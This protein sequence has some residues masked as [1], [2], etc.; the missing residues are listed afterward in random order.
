MNHIIEILGN[1]KLKSDII[2]QIHNM[3]HVESFD[4]K[5]DELISKIENF[6]E[7]TSSIE[8]LPPI[9]ENIILSVGRPVIEV[10]HNTFVPPTSSE[11]ANKLI[12]YRNN[13][14]NAIP[15][16]GR[17][18]VKDHPSF[19][20]LGTG[21]LISKNV[22]V[23]NGHIAELFAKKSGS[24]FSFKYNTLRNKQIQAR[25]DFREEYKIPDQL[26]FNVE[27]VLYIEEDEQKP[28]LAF[29]QISSQS[30]P[31]ASLPNPIS[32]SSEGITENK[33]VVIIG[34]PA[35]DSRVGDPLE[36]ERI[37]GSVYDVKRIAPG[38]AKPS[39]DSE[40]E[41]LI[42]HDCS[43]LGGNSGSVVLDIETGK[44]VGL[45][46]GGRYLENNYAVSSTEVN[47]ILNN[48]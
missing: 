37:F 36:M 45:H 29:L 41:W 11:W 5:I 7:G 38:I 6:Q 31:E 19:E 39:G 1:E 17:I 46:F 2:S 44:A 23:T 48:L 32:L 14:E 13:I 35:K 28:D 33:D 40:Q 34:Y 26:E 16:V 30:S 15:A 25:I 20:W 8:N 43:T 22:I 24:E 27:K 12:K 47:K 4:Y 3:D 10:R 21:W 42:Y 18:E 9:L